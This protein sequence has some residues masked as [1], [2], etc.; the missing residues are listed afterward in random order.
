M[1]ERA[2]RS[3]AIA[4]LALAFSACD[5]GDVVAPRTPANSPEANPPTQNTTVVIDIRDFAFQ[6]P[7]GTDSITITLGQ[8]VKWMCAIGGPGIR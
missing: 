4:T 1:H 8:T 2:K 5:A 7:S 3:A 6:T